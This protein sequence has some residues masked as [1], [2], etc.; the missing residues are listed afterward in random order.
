M[1]CPSEILRVPK[2][3]LVKIVFYCMCVNVFFFTFLFRYSLVRVCVVALREMVL[4][5]W[6]CLGQSLVSTLQPSSRPT[7]PGWQWSTAVN[8][9]EGNTSLSL[10]S[11]WRRQN[12]RRHPQVNTH[13]WDYCF[14]IMFF[15]PLHTGILT[16]VLDIGLKDWQRK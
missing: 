13:Q 7:R 6:V 9:H 2:I 16:Q 10:I 3:V 1:K 4:S 8:S 12:M 11:A 5:V 14:V 15:S